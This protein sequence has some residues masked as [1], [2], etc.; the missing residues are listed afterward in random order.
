MMSD[1]MVSVLSL[2]GIQSFVALS[3]YLLLISGQLSFGQQAYFGVG[4][5]VGAATTAMLGFSFVAALVAGALTAGVLATAVAAL[6]FRLGGLYFAVATLAFAELMRL[7]WMNLTYQINVNGFLIGP[8]GTEGFGDIRYIIDNDI[9]PTGYLWIITLCLLLVLIVFFV[10][11]RS[12]FGLALRMIDNDQ[13]AAAS[14][15]ISPIRHKIASAALAGAIA[16]VGGVLFAHYMTFIDP[17]NFGVMLGVHALVYGL[18]GGLG[19]FLGPLIGV[20]ID[21]GL[22]E[23]LRVFNGFRMIVFGALV[24]V[25]LI[26]RPRGLLDEKTVHLISTRARTWLKRSQ[27]AHVGI[28]DEPN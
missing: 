28:S 22:L 12:R 14:L 26:F 1:Y 15:G 24:V 9:S 7:T 8:N 21:I 3:T 19:T 16:G 18:I 6:T 11:G 17:R 27:P 2:I 5:F 13:T 20:C 25:I 10:L 4:A 23:S